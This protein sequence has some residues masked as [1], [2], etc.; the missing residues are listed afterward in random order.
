MAKKYVSLSKLSTFLDK[1]KETFSELHHSH[2]INE[3]TDFNID[4]EL[5]SNSVNPVQNKILNA[6]FESIS[7]ALDIYEKALDEK[8]DGIHAHAI[9][10]VNGLQTKL[11]NLQSSIEA[12]TSPAGDSLGTVMSGGNVTIKDGI[13]TVLDDS[14]SHIIDNID[15]L[16]DILTVKSDVGHNHDDMYYTESEID[17]KVSEINASIT[18]ITNGDIVVA[19]ASHALAADSSDYASVAEKATQDDN[20]NVITATYETK[21]DAATKL[22]EAKSYA[23]SIKNDLLNGAGAAYDTLKELGDL[24]DDNTDAIDA[25]ET[26]ASGK[27]DKVHTHEVS[28]INGLQTTLDTIEENIAQKSQVQIITWEADD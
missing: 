7:L 21:T 16:Q 28:D 24:I 12:S 20:G 9:A 8:A 13:I 11:D 3:I 19:K 15:G 18:C 26:V 14:H 25:L 23:D 1:L 17:T 10:E 4:N 2:T 27:A 6:E 22:G 5:S